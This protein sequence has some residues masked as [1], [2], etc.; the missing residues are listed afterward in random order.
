ML[1]GNFF[2]I[3]SFTCTRNEEAQQNY[4]AVASLIES[5]PIYQGH[6]PGNPVVP[7]V[8]QVQMVK[9]LVE[10]AVKH[11]V[12]L[13]ES[14]NIKFLSMINPLVHPQLDFNIFIK[15]AGVHRFSVTA[16][17][18]SGELVFLKFKGKFESAG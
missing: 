5:H 18:E 10:K 1:T 9:E 15:P 8:C 14:D 16:S 2:D 4:H 3:Q 7:G 6:F 13:T 12:K 17:I 11:S